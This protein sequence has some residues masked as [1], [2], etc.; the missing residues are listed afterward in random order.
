[1][2]IIKSIDEEGRES[3]NV[4]PD[5]NTET[6]VAD[7]KERGHTQ[8]HDA[9]TGEKYISPEDIITALENGYDDDDYNDPLQKAMN[10]YCSMWDIRE[11][12]KHALAL[13]LRDQYQNH[14]DEQAPDDLITLAKILN[15]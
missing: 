11:G 1:M 4:Q 3:T 10:Y 15:L 5:S 9:E 7:L 8:I 13:T 6:T 2:S 14:P 12:Y